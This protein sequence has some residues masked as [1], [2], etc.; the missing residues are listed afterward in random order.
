[1]GDKVMSWHP[2]DIGGGIIPLTVGDGVYPLTVGPIGPIYYHCSCPHAGFGGNHLPGCPF[3]VG[4]AD[5]SE[6]YTPTKGWE[7]P[8]CGNVYSPTWFFCFKCNKIE[9]TND[10]KVKTT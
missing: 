7:C 8:K 6:I 3:Y 9:V 5:F 2:H 10:N 1:M 4:Y